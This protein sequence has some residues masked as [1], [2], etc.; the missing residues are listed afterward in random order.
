MMTERVSALSFILGENMADLITLEEFKLVKD[1]TKTDKD[2][3]LAQLI[4]NASEIIQLYIGKHFY[5]GEQT[6]TEIIDLDY[7]TDVIYLEN[8]PITSIEAITSI[9]P[10]SHDS[11][12][13]FPVPD[14]VY[15][16][17]LRDGKLYRVDKR[18]WPTGFGAVEVTYKIGGS[19]SSSISPALKQVT[20]D[21]VQYYRDEEY[22]DS[23]SMRG[24]TINNNTGSGQSNTAST[25]FPP[26]IQRVLDLIKKNGSV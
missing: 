23:R 2:D 10:Y 4:T 15:K 22:K 7:F 11:S 5:S 3:L 26:H 19:L 25:N 13:H 12:V 24:A 21:L 14:V 6:I 16:A 8:Y 17:D 9:D 20:I 18:N 1:I